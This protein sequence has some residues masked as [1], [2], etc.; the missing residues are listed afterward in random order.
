VDVPRFA[1]GSRLK[2]RV[3]VGS[4]GS[5]HL[6]G[7]RD[8][9]LD[10]DCEFAN[11]GSDG[12]RCAP[13]QRA[14]Y[15]AGVFADDQCQDRA[16]GFQTG[17][18][19][20]EH[21]VGSTTPTACDRL[22]RRDVMLV[23]ETTV[24]PFS[25]SSGTCEPH[26]TEEPGM[27]WHAITPADP[28]D[29][30]AG[31]LE[32]IDLGGGLSLSLV[33][34]EDGA[35]FAS[36]FFVDEHP[37]SAVDLTDAGVRCA[38]VPQV[39]LYSYFLND[40]CTSELGYALGTTGCA[41]PEY[42]PIRRVVSQGEC[43]VSAVTLARVTPFLGT[44]VFSDHT[45]TCA[46]LTISPS[47]LM[48]VSIGEAASG[49]SLPVLGSAESGTARLRG[50][51]YQTENGSRVELTSSIFDSELDELCTPTQFEDG[52]TRCMPSATFFANYFSDAS[53]TLPIAPEPSPCSTQ[54]YFVDAIE[55]DACSE[56]TVVRA[57]YRTTTAHSGPVYQIGDGE[58][59]IEAVDPPYLFLEVESVDSAE[60]VTLTEAL[61]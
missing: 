29:F 14:T 8:T 22:P 24:A 23:G 3:H 17:C 42:V 55:N 30:V 50:S 61:E 39:N 15:D 51:V 2:T 7:F 56:N 57:L 58:A 52:V 5:R 47:G 45:G 60:L 34:A 13:L 28:T 54:R 25:Q 4:D 26:T 41:L 18:G 33:E 48:R 11:L 27:E 16:I 53:C 6:I 35:R 36:S 12:Y 59:C 32:R 37:C 21:Y 20:R 46:P 44:E 49:E 38:P 19:Q 31:T 10:L 43:S 9:E 40:T 1:S